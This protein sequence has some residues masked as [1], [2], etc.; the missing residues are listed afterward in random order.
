MRGDEIVVA[1]SLRSPAAIGGDDVG[2]R[3]F[4]RRAREPPRWRWRRPR[5]LT[6]DADGGLWPTAML[7]DG[8]DVRL[9]GLRGRAA[10]GATTLE[11]TADDAALVRLAGRAITE[12]V[13]FTGAGREILASPAAATASRSR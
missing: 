12:V 3:G 2:P 10:L 7:V 6:L 4:H 1:S 11:A 9:A 5:R 13:A 8:D